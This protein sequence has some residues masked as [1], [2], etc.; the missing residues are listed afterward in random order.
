M[1]PRIS[2]TI[3][4]SVG[5]AV[6]AVAMALWSRQSNPLPPL[7]PSRMGEAPPIIMVADERPAHATAMEAD[8]VSE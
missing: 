7:P 8:W 1:H 4:V 6:M 2:T 5:L 3:G